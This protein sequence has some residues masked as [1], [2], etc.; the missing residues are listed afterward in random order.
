MSQGDHMWSTDVEEVS[1]RWEGEVGDGPLVPLT[2]CDENDICKKLDLCPDMTNVHQ[3]LN[4]LARF[5]GLRWLLSEHQKEAGGLPPAED[6]ERWELLGSDLDD[7]PAKREKFSTK[8]PHSATSKSSVRVSSAENV[9]MG[10]ASSSSA[11]IK[12]LVNA[13]SKKISGIQ[14]ARDILLRS[15]LELPKTHYLP[16]K[17]AV[18]KQGLS[19]LCR[20]WDQTERIVHLSSNHDSSAKPLTVKRGA[21]SMLQVTAKRAARAKDGEQSCL[22]LPPAQSEQSNVVDAKAVEEQIVDE[23]VM[24][25]DNSQGGI[26]DKARPNAKEQAGEAVE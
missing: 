24:E 4:I 17:E 20:S 1:G 25:E 26:A 13:N 5:C 3:A 12:C 18:V 2:Y 7:L 8:L 9:P 19:C 21:D 22:D 16:C 11:R 14:E 23:A 6:V 15:P 10:V